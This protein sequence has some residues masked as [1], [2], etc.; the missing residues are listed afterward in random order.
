MSLLLLFSILYLGVNLG[1]SIQTVVGAVRQWEGIKR[2][3]IEKEIKLCLC[4]CYVCSWC[5]IHK[6]SQRSIRKPLE[7]ITNVAGYRI[8]FKN[9]ISFLFCFFICLFFETG[10]LFIALAVLELTL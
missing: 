2:T 7:I 8:H 3:Q 6:K 10:F 9:S 1:S 5:T 4:I